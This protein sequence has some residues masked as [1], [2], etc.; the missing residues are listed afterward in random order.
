M[1]FLKRYISLFLIIAVFIQPLSYAE[2]TLQSTQ[3]S[4]GYINLLKKAAKS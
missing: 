3:R 2:E 1:R 4:V